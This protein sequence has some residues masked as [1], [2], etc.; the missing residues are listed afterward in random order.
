MDV[1][2]FMFAIALD[3]DLGLIFRRLIDCLSYVMICLILI[4]GLDFRFQDR[5]SVRR[6]FRFFRY[7]R[8]SVQLLFFIE[9]QFT[10]SISIILL[11]MYMCFLE[12]RFV[13]LI[14][15]G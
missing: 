9:R 8:V 14:N 11:S 12:G 4:T 6:R 15:G 13:R 2:L 7:V 5:D 1:C 10:G 3:V